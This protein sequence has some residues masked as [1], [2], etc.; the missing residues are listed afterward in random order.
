MKPSG[1]TSYAVRG[2]LNILEKEYRKTKNPFLGRIIKELSKPTR[3]R[4]DINLSKINRFTEEGDN[5][6][7]LGKVLSSGELKHKINIIAFKYSATAVAKLKASKSTI[8][9]LADW[10]RKPVAPEKVKIIG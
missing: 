7:A 9:L 2:I 6:F 8:K 1:P 3:K 5:V 4:R 10:A